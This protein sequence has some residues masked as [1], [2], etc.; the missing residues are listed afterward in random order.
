MSRPDVYTH[1]PFRLGGTHVREYSAETIEERLLRRSHLLPNGCRVWVGFLRNGYGL[2]R[3]PNWGKIQAVHRVAYETWVGPIPEGLTI[4]HL[5][6]NRACIEPTHL[7]AVPIG[8]NVKRGK[9]AQTHCKNG[10][11]F[12]GSNLQIAPNGWRNCRTCRRDITARYRHK[13]T[14]EGLR[15]DGKPRRRTP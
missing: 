14:S 4:D 1:Y 6:R 10:H 2:V 9:A 12:E 3:R 15:V 11:P 13:F 8:V 5:C 7:E